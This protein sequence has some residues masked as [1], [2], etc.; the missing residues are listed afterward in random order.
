MT[1]DIEKGI[2]V[3]DVYAVALLELASAADAAD[4]T[5]AELEELARLYETDAQFAAFMSATAVDDDDRERSLDTIFH[6]RLSDLVLNTLQVM[7]RHGRSALVRPLLRAYDLRLQEAR[8]QIEVFATSAIEL[9]PAQKSELESVAATL[10]GKKPIVQ[11][12]VDPGIIGGLVLQIGDRR[13]DNSIRRRLVTA[14]AHLAERGD[15]GL[16]RP[17]PGS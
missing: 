3:A 7:N 16:E 8:G 10:S 15:R 4:E 6:G 5:R 1:P 2:D 9:N 17:G 11:Y 12:R 13:Y 14:H